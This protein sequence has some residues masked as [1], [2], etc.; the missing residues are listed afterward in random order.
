M[1][2]DSTA[3]LRLSWYARPA[4]VPGDAEAVGVQ[5]DAGTAEAHGDT[6]P[7]GPANAA[8]SDGARPPAGRLVI[9]TGVFDVLHVGHVRFLNAARAAGDLLVVGV[10]DDVRVTAWKGPR[11]PVHPAV[12]RA[13]ML[14]ALRP[15]DGV[16]VIHGDPDLRQPEPYVE[17]LAP[18]RAAVYAFTQGDPVA[19][20]KHRAA[21]M[22]G[23]KALEVPLVPQRSTTLLLQRQ[24]T[25][26]D[27]DGSARPA[28]A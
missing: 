12:E 19:S 3:A 24:A 14:S 9:A 1:T 25:S 13:E 27:T 28:S 8:E 18:L 4:G 7:A 21:R 15:V 11:R 26:G 2:E 6:R 20:E 16:F 22:L 5:S 10:E 17:L 23:M